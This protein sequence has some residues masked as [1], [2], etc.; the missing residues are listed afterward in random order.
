M[1]QRAVAAAREALS[2]CSDLAGVT[3]ES[4]ARCIG[5]S[6]AAC[7]GPETGASLSIVVETDTGCV[8]GT[9]ALSER[10]EQPEQVRSVV[11]CGGC[12]RSSWEACDR[13]CRDRQ[14]QLRS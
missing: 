13:T 4:A 10:K 3:V 14:L 7:R 8:L 1:A 11:L 2:S 5:P 6:E 9:N 12:T